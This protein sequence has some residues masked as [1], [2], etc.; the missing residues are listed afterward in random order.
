MNFD[1]IPG[2]RWVCCV[3]VFFSSGTQNMDAPADCQPSPEG[4][5]G[6]IICSIRCFLQSLSADMELALAVSPAAEEFQRECVSKI[7]SDSAGLMR[8]SLRM[9]NAVEG[10]EGC[11]I[12]A[13]EAAQMASLVDA[14]VRDSLDPALFHDAVASFCGNSLNVLR[15]HCL[16]LANTFRVMAEEMTAAGSLSGH[17]AALQGKKRGRLHL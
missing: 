15:E 8:M 14:F 17:A 2:C 3:Y 7:E 9:Y 4:N 6:P 16:L 5:L 1:F 13:D 10:M 11:M 12:G